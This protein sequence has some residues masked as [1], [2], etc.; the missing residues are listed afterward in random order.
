MVPITAFVL[1]QIA[2]FG[3]L[4]PEHLAELCL[5]R[6]RKSR[7]YQSLR[8]L[9]RLRLVQGQWLPAT[10]RPVYGITKLGAQFV[11]QFVD[12]ES[13]RLPT[14]NEARH[15]L[16]VAETL[17]ELARYEY[18]TGFATENELSKGEIWCATRTRRPDAVFQVERE[19]KTFE[20][21][22]EVETSH[23]SR[24]RVLAIIEKY[25]HAFANGAFCKGVF[26]VCDTPGIHRS[27]LEELK[28]LDPDLQKKIVVLLGPKVPM[29]R[30]DLYGNP[31][32]NPGKCAEK[33]RTVFK[34][35]FEPIRYSPMFSGFPIRP[36]P[37]YPTDTGIGSKIET[38]EGVNTAVLGVVS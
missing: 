34:G 20:I 4:R 6:A 38:N 18:V 23:K 16:R 24:D 17:T 29:L 26:V 22:L 3:F 27:Y 32:K 5:G 8:T 14:L 33:A 28:E 7:I 15:Q 10:N 21:A 35:Q 9:H 13:Y 31:Y 2:R 25:R 11:A 19:G 30:S 12:R 36:E 1:F 37:P